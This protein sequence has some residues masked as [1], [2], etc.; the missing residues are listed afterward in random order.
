MTARTVG[1][2]P[3]WYDDPTHEA[4]LRYWDG[5][6]WSPYVAELDVAA[7]EDALRLRHEL[8]AFL[9]YLGAQG[10]ITRRVW[11]RLDLERLKYASGRRA[12]GRCISTRRPWRELVVS[13]PPR[14]PHQPRRPR[15]RRRRHRRLRCFHRPRGRC[16]RGP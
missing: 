9:D 13:R 16:Q 11:E 1:C 5:Q 3:G 10:L 7:K 8:G 12:C 4:A 14:R 6:A 15:H 2:L